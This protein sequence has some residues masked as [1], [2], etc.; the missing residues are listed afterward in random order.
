MVHPDIIAEIPGVETE[1]MYDNLIGPT[2]IGKEEKPSLYAERALIARN[3][4]GLD[5][6]DQARGVDKKQDEV[7]VID[8]EDDDDV[9]GVFIKDELVDRFSVSGEDVFQGKK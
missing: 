4:A 6:V 3:N 5:T 9:P 1:D 7:M 2:P 8:D